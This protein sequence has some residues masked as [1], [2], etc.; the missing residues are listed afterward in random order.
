MVENLNH[1]AFVIASYAL[2]VIGTATLV[3]SSLLAMRRAEARK[4]RTREP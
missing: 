1:W 3:G 4:D 2:T